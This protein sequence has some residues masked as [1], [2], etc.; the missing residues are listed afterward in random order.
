MQC[1]LTVGGVSC[2]VQGGVRT[3][4]TLAVGG[5]SCAAQYAMRGAWMHELGERS[6]AC[7]CTP[8]AEW[9]TAVA[10]DSVEQDSS[11]G[12]PA[13]PGWIQTGSSCYT[14]LPKP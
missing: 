11:V 1:R 2:A 4:R 14:C 7:G 9:Q 12:T 3:R 8:K 5:V 13:I 10:K 6:V